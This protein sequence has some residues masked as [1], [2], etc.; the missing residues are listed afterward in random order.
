MLNL[1]SDSRRS[2]RIVSVSWRRPSSSIEDTINR[3]S[4]VT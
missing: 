4:K 2:L 3:V 1:A